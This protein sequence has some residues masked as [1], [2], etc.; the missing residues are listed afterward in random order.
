MP[1]PY[2]AWYNPIVI[3]GEEGPILNRPR[4]VPPPRRDRL[5]RTI[6]THWTGIGVIIKI[7]GD[8]GPHVNFDIPLLQLVPEAV[9]H[10]TDVRDVDFTNFEVETLI[11]L[12]EQNLVDGSQFDLVQNTIV[13]TS[14]IAEKNITSSVDYQNILMNVHRYLVVHG[15]EVHVEFRNVAVDNP[16]MP[17]LDVTTVARYPPVPKIVT[18][19]VSYP[20]DAEAMEDGGRFPKNRKDRDPMYVPGTPDPDSDC[21]GLGPRLGANSNAQDNERPHRSRKRTAP[22]LDYEDIIKYGLW[23]PASPED[24]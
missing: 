6:R 11:A 1:R 17:P 2:G 24:D 22:S 5:T 14:G 21:P 23:R 18:I 7:A 20:G 16:A 10:D 12:C 3:D 19:P 13:C 15:A 9:S 4:A 8:D